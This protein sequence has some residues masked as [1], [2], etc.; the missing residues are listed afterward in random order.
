M[1]DG[2]GSKVDGLMDGLSDVEKPAIVELNRKLKR[3]LDAEKSIIAVLDTM[4]KKASGLVVYGLNLSEWAKKTKS[5]DADAFKKR[6]KEF[7][8]AIEGFE[9]FTDA[10]DGLL[11][12]KAVGRS[13][14]PGDAFQKV[15]DALQFKD[16]AQIANLRKAALDYYPSES[17][18]QKKLQEWAVHL[19]H[20]AAALNDGLAALDP[21]DKVEAL[22]LNFGKFEV[23][24]P[25][26]ELKRKID[27]LGV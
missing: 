22:H 4:R 20:L 21:S 13:K 7:D 12:G 8:K 17:A 15:L 9:S 18:G 11:E 27:S 25:A 26:I 2:I 5:P 10:I 1:S 16:K 14:L 19:S 3:Y 24:Q 6:S 23:M